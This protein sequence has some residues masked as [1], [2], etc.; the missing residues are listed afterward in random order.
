[1]RHDDKRE[2]RELKRIVKRAGH[3]HARNIVKRVLTEDPDEAPFVAENF[4]RHISAE[5]NGVD[6]AARAR[7]ASESGE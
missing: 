2:H 7:R 6:R 1:M 4:G 5:M 3:K